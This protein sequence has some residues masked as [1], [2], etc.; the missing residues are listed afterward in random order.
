MSRCLPLPKGRK[1]FSFW[2]SETVMLGE[3]RMCWETPLV[4]GSHCGLRRE[5]W[6]AQHEAQ[7]EGFGVQASGCF[8]R[9]DPA[10]GQGHST[11]A[12]WLGRAR[13]PL[14]KHLEGPPCLCRAAVVLQA[15]WP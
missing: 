14:W 1:S 2:L 11:R 7:Q 15:G 9:E 4:A 8:M 12:S 3:E 5:P 13:S 6:L 10:P